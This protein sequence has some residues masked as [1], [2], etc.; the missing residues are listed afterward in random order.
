MASQALLRTQ[1][2]RLDK[3]KIFIAK[4]QIAALPSLFKFLPTGTSWILQTPFPHDM[5]QLR[6]GFNKWLD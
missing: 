1:D 2:Y 4:K 6:L 5:C 3:H